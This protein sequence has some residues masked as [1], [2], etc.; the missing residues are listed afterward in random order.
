M[1]LIIQEQKK[2]DDNN[3]YKEEE[4]IIKINQE[5]LESLKKQ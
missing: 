1:A 5:I 2:V 4:D 3:K